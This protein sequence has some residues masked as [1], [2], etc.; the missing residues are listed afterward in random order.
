MDDDE[1]LLFA[2]RLLLE[3][4]NT[5]VFTTD[6]VDKAQEIA[7]KEKIHLAILDYM[8]PKLRGDQLARRLIQIDPEIKIIFVSGYNE[9]IEVAKKLDFDIYGVFMKPF[10]P[11]VMEK[12]AES[13]DHANFIQNSIEMPP[14][15]MYSNIVTD[16]T[17]TGYF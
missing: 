14:L 10:D 4:E 17:N 1:D 5:A 7:R 3:K 2:Y 16:N 6:D 8:M 15:N 13:N 9:V 11:D 12:L